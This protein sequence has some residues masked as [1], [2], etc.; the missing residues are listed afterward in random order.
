MIRYHAALLWIHHAILFLF[1]GYDDLD[2]LHQVFLADQLAAFL[3]CQKRTLIDH[4]GKVG[5]CRAGGGERQLMQ[6]DVLGKLHFC[7]V[8]A[9]N[10]FTPR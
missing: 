2:R 4:V 7:G 5:A 8:Y 1:A 6:I 3:Y 10:R 9:E